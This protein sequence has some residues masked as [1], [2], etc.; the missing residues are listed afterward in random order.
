MS[1]IIAV[2]VYAITPFT[3]APETS[4]RS[5]LEI[6]SMALFSAVLLKLILFPCK[7]T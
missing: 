5:K 6:P 4:S 7:V 1:L 3:P 2:F